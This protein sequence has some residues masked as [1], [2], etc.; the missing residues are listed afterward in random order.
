MGRKLN[1]YGHPVDRTGFEYDEGGILDR[2]LAERNSVLI[3][4]PVTGEWIFSLESAEQTGGEYE[5]GVLV[6]RPGNM[7]PPEH[8]HPSYEERFEVLQGE[9][10]FLV[11]GEEVHASVG[12]RVV[13]A[14]GVRHTFRCVGDEYGALTGE[15]WP[16]ANIVE[17]LKTM[18][19]M[20]HDERLLP[21]GRPHFLH[22]MVMARAF[23][24]NTV[25]TTPPPEIVLPLSY[26]V[27]PIAMALGVELIQER[28]L[29]D[30]FWWRVCEQPVDP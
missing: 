16:A 21:D 29:D 27:A 20:A 19:G 13:V 23:A 18:F 26:V 25:F 1:A 3:S 11:E 24:N 6:L 7:G 10:V 9:F 5:R 17:V 2:L 22:A 12:D 15:T 8:Y 30:N 28:Y 14:P 4:Q